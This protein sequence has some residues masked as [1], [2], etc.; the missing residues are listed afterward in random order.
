MKGCNC[1][2][3]EQYLDPV[4]LGVQADLQTTL[5]LAYPSGRDQ[6]LDDHGARP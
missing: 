5:E 1:A 2:W 3:R 4:K 6:Q